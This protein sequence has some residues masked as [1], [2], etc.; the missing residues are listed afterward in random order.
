MNQLA[1]VE[2]QHKPIHKLREVGG[3]PQYCWHQLPAVPPWFFC[4]MHTTHNTC[5]LQRA[6]RRPLP[7]WRKRR[8]VRQYESF[9]PACRIASA[10]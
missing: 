4:R 3:M 9:Q 1:P 2:V 6:R 5:A 7:T 10:G 8:P